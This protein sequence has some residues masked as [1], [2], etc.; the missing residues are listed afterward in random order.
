MVPTPPVTVAQQVYLARYL[1]SDA[2]GGFAAVGLGVHDRWLQERD[3]APCIPDV[4][5]GVVVSAGRWYPELASGGVVVELIDPS[6]AAIPLNEVDG[7]TAFSG[8]TPGEPYR[9]AFAIQHHDVRTDGTGLHH[10]RVTTTVG[11]VRGRGVTTIV[12]EVELAVH[13]AAASADEA[14]D[15]PPT[16]GSLGYL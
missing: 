3:G 4:G 7:A 14:A 9:V 11:G 15:P 10:L 5:I 12:S 1:S 6:G 16:P 2:D 8:G 13:A